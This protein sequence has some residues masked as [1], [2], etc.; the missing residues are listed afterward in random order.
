[1]CACVVA[2][3]SVCA[4]VVAGGSVCVWWRCVRVCRTV[5]T[6]GGPTLKPNDKSHSNSVKFV[7]VREQFQ[8]L[9]AFGK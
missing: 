7:R 9:L 2:G 1:M 4:C 5:K 6:N 3:G 8:T